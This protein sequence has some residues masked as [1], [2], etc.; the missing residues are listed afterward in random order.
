MIRVEKTQKDAN[1]S[2]FINILL[3][4]KRKSIIKSIHNE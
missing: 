4:K 2:F 3:N 1:P